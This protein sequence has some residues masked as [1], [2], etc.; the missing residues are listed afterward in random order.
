MKVSGCPALC[1]DLIVAKCIA[2][3]KIKDYSDALSV[4]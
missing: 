4:T 3:E 2:K 1:A